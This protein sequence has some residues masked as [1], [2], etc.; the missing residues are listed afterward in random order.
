[1]REGLTHSQCTNSIV[2]LDTPYGDP[3]IQLGLFCDSM[4]SLLLCSQALAGGPAPQPSHY[5]VGSS[6]AAHMQNA[7][8]YELQCTKKQF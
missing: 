6:H 7:G 4:S 3:R 5:K 8:P 1:M 2:G